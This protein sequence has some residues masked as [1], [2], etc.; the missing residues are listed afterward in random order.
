L[1]LITRYHGIF[2]LSYSQRK[3][4]WTASQGIGLIN[5]DQI[6]LLTVHCYDD[7]IKEKEAERT[8]EDV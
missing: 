5:F 7:A 8:I 6:N 2:D 1:H 3:S 4:Q